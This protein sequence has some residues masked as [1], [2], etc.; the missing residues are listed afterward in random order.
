M[1]RKRSPPGSGEAIVS[2]VGKRA[3]GHWIGRAAG[4]HQGTRGSQQG[5]PMGI[6][7]A[8]DRQESSL[9]RDVEWWETSLER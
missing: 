7:P 8:R 9:E 5:R 6:K 4:E 2:L 1:Q 3:D